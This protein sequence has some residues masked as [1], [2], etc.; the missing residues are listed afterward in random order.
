MRRCLP[1]LLLLLSACST[2]VRENVKTTFQSSQPWRPSIDVRADAVMVYG[3]NG[4]LEERL[5]SWQERGYETHFMT[6]I[7]W[8]AY[9]DYF[10]GRWDGQPHL[11]E[12]QVNAAGDT[13][14][15]GRMVPYIVPTENY[16]K[17]FKERHIKRVMLLS[18]DIYL[19]MNF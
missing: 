1:F 8:G 18:R 4:T 3:V 10:T 12:G 17:Y 11:D 9:Q 7:A 5:A 13:L 2:P 16:L 6:G 15:H 14:W 19:W